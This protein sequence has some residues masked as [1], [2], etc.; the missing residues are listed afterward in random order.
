[1]D[2]TTQVQKYLVTFCKALP[3]HVDCWRSALQDSVKPL[4]NLANLCEQQRAIQNVKLCNFGDYSDAQ[5]V[6]LHRI[7]IGIEEELL[8]IKKL[9]DKVNECNIDLK[10]KLLVFERST[11]NLNWEENNELIRGNGSQPPLAK[12]LQYSLQFLNYFTKGAKDISDKL[13]VLNVKNV[14]SVKQLKNSFDVDLDY[15]IVKDLLALTQY[16]DNEKEIT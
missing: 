14:K 4:Q 8:C 3:A 2:N 11:L 7:A 9:V 5:G 1:M 12:L 16:V 15:K 10:N 13:K 6:I